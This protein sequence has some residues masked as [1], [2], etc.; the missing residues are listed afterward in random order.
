MRVTGA[1]GGDLRPVKNARAGGLSGSGQPEREIQ[2]M[3]VP[4]ASV[5]RAAKGVGRAEHFRHFRALDEADLVVAVLV[6][7][8]G[9]IVAGLS[10]EACA[11][12][13]V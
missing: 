10:V 9:R 13:G 6:L 3:N 8:L 12:V 7:Q 5:E 4:A 1:D 11:V 2:R